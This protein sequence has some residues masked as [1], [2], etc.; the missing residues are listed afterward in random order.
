MNTLKKVVSLAILMTIPIAITVG[1][2][3]T[4]AQW[5]Q[6][7]G[8]N[9]GVRGDLFYGKVDTVGFNAYF[10][11]QNIVGNFFV[12]AFIDTTSGDSNVSNGQLKITSVTLEYA[13]MNE[14]KDTLYNVDSGKT[15][16]MAIGSLAAAETW[17]RIPLP[18]VGVC[19][20]LSIRARTTDADTTNIPAERKTYLRWSLEGE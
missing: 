15:W 11:T 19:N 17:Y 6:R 18:E 1:V 14:N 2:I 12:S 20:G 4:H 3:N 9:T 5:M 13:Y 10:N 7:F 16:Q 8:G